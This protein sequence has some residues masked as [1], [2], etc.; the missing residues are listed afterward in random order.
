MSEHPEKCGTITKEK[1]EALVKAARDKAKGGTDK[2]MGLEVGLEAVMSL[3]E[4]VSLDEDEWK[5]IK[6]RKHKG[7]AEAVVNLC[8]ETDEKELTFLVGPTGGM[9]HPAGKNGG[10]AQDSGESGIVLCCASAKAQRGNNMCPSLIAACR[11]RVVL[12][13]LFVPSKWKTEMGRT[14]PGSASGLSTAAT[15][16]GAFKVLSVGAGHHTSEELEDAFFKKHQGDKMKK[17]WLDAC[18]MAIV[19][20]LHRCEQRKFPVDHV[21]EVKEMS[22]RVNAI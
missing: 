12:D 4:S 10:D 5:E 16:L 9:R 11:C 2:S 17:T 3:F 15:S 13:N 1:V 22:N 6:K 18:P 8:N 21:D 20:R 19:I 7:G 14:I